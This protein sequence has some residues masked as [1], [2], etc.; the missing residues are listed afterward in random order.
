MAET[1]EKAKKPPAKK[2]ARPR[3]SPKVK[4]VYDVAESYFAAVAARDPKAMAAHWH[5][6]GV[7]DIVPLGVFRGP[8]AVQSL[9]EEMFGAIPDFTFIVDRIT[10]DAEVATVQWRAH[11]KFTGTPFRGIEATGRRI[12]L[13]GCDCVEVVDGKLVRNTAYYDGA[14]FARSIGLLPPEN[15]GADKA[16]LAGFNAVTKLRRAVGAQT[17]GNK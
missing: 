2:P 10:A 3:R 13:R 11:G 15:S 8:A 14:A 12:D 9:F 1:Q 5:E 17:G 16:M 4:A 6:D 7:E